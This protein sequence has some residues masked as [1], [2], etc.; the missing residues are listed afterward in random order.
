[1]LIA[2]SKKKDITILHCITEYPAPYSDVNLK[3]MN[4]IKN[5]FS[6]K[7]GYSDHTLGIEVSLAAVAMGAEIIE[8]HITLKNSDEGPDHKASLEPYQFKNLVSSIRNISLSLGT[9]EK[10]IRNSELKNIIVARKSIVAKEDIKKNE[11]FSE[12]NLCSKRPGNGLSPMLWDKV[13]GTRATRD[14]KVND[15]IKLD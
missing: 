3:A 8:K 13:I 6:T 7:V 5:K 4:A 10:K 14:Y 11:L 1:M 15:F 12:K 2:G 9:E